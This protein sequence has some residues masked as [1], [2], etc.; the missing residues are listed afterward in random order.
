ML[1]CLGGTEMG[2]LWASTVLVTAQGFLFPS[3][4]IRWLLKLID[5]EFINIH[6]SKRLKKPIFMV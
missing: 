2:W 3:F 6:C 4:K 1:L 5:C